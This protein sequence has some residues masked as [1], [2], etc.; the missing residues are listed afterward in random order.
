MVNTSR[1]VRAAIVITA[2]SGTVA[3]GSSFAQAEYDRRIRV[4]NFTSET[5]R[6]LYASNVGTRVWEEDI[7]GSGIIPA[8]SSVVVNLYDG[9]GYCRFDLKAVFSDGAVVIRE[10]VNICEL[11]DWNLYEQ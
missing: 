1:F 4:N 3:P 5:L 7:L 9:S 6:E 10:R 8:G 2:L 11:T